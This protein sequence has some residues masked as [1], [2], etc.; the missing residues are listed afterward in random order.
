[1][2]IKRGSLWL[3]KINKIIRPEMRQLAYDNYEKTDDHLMHIIGL[4][5]DKNEN[6]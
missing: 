5:K 2:Q 1:M 6:K 4:A 3:K